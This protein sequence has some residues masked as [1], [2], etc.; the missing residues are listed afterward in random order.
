[1]KYLTLV[2]EMAKQRITKKIYPIC[3]KFTGIA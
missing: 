2:G 1:M 3:L